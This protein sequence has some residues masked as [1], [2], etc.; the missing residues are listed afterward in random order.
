MAVPSRRNKTKTLIK[1]EFYARRNKEFNE[2][3]KQS[4]NE[5]SDSEHKERIGLLRQLGLINGAKQD[6]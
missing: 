6:G 5:I 4:K 3:L 2:T 1:R